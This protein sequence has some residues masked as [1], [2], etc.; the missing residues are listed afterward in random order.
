MVTLY[1]YIWFGAAYL[2]RQLGA[3]CRFYQN[4]TAADEW[5]IR[6]LTTGLLMEW[7]STWS[8]SGTKVGTCWGVTR[9]QTPVNPVNI[10]KITSMETIICSNLCNTMV[11]IT[12]I[13]V[14]TG[15]VGISYGDNLLVWLRI[16]CFRQLAA[17]LYTEWKTTWSWRNWSGTKVA[18]GGSE[19]AINISSNVC[20]YLGTI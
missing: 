4:S 17:G 7:R 6:Q 1:I 13:N 18:C 2:F 3:W 5:M 10:I 14:C 11:T 12:N 8:L 19:T 20:I 16:L 15:N 9:E